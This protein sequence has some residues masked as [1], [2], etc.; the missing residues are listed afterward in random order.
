MRDDVQKCYP[1]E[2]CGLVTGR[3]E[4][5]LAVIPVTNIL[6]SRVRYRMDPHEQLR[7]FKTI[8]EN[9]WDLAAIYHSHPDGPDTPSQTD[10]AE[11]YYPDVIQL[12][13][14]KKNIDWQ[15]KGF[16]IQAGSVTNVPIQVMEDQ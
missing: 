12:I 8:E 16:Y 3:A 1:E 15:C 14:F 6:H 9:D 13:W 10:I 7:V 2:A 4:R 11:C 5:V